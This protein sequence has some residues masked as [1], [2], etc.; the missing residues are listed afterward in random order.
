MR[1]ALDYVRLAEA[2]NGAIP[3]AVAFDYVWGDALSELK[4]AQ[5]Q[6]RI[7]NLETSVT[8]SGRIPPEG[9]QLPDEP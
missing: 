7:I 8:K 1:S 5:P 9:H 6:A 2:A 4:R 3:R